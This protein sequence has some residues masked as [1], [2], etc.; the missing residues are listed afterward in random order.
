MSISE[1]DFK[2][3][4]AILFA[5]R[6]QERRGI[7]DETIAHLLDVLDSLRSKDGDYDD[8]A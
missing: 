2:L 1:H 4:R 3:L 6:D 7:D 8:C 5:Y